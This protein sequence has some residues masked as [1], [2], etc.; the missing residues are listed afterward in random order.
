MYGPLPATRSRPYIVSQQAGLGLRQAIFNTPSRIGFAVLR[1]ASIHARL[2][3]FTAM[4]PMAWLSF[5][6]LRPPQPYPTQP[7]PRQTRLPAPA[8]QLQPTQNAATQPRCRVRKGTTR[9]QSIRLAPGLSV[10]P[11]ELSNQA[12][13][14]GPPSPPG[15]TERTTMRGCH[16]LIAQH[17]Q[18]AGR[19]PPQRL[20]LPPMPRSGAPA[21]SDS[22]R[23]PVP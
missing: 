8:V 1:L 22:R 19:G 2:H 3:W 14:G 21:G 12:I 9:G 6:I 20:D 23:N 11:A 18:H 10:G 4:R 5:R 15:P 13:K 16:R 7:P 17:P